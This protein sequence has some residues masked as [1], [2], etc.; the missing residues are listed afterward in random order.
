VTESELMTEGQAAFL[1]KE[2]GFVSS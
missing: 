2:W 1:W